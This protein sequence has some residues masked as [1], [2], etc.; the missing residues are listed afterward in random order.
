MLYKFKS[1][2]S[3]DLIMLPADGARMLDILIG[4][5]EPQGIVTLAQLPEAIARLEAAVAID[6]ARREARRKGE[7][8]GAE[9]PLPA[10]RLAQRAAPMLKMLRQCLREEADLVWG[11]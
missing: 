11:V 8:D 7:E 6:E 1:K 9:D 4:H 10:V 5:S 2:V 3:A